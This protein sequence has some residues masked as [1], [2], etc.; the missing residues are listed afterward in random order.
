MGLIFIGFASSASAVTIGSLTYDETISGNEVI[1][2][3]MNNLEWLRWDVLENLTYAETLSIIGVGGNYEGWNIATQS[4][5]YMFTD[6]LLGPSV[7]SSCTPNLFEN[8]NCGDTT[9]D[10]G[11]VLGVAQF[12]SGDHASFYLSDSSRVGFVTVSNGAS[13]LQINNWADI[14][15]SDRFSDSGN[16]SNVSWMLYRNLSSDVVAAP[17]SSSIYLLAFGLLGLFGVARRKV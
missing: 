15:A 6:A 17:E 7:V 16:A 4:F 1:T 10:A 9:S 12:T 14:A 13:I 11:E 5:A 3:S 8:N 2:D